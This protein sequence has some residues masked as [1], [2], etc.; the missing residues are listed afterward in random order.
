MSAST[1]A[2]HS[3][4]TVAEI[5][6][7]MTTYAL[8]GAA[9]FVA[10]RHLH[11]IRDTGGKLVAAVDPHDSVGVLD[12]YFPE[13]RYFS[14]VERFDRH[15]EKLRRIGNGVDYVSICTPNYLHD[16]HVRLALRLRAHAIC[17]KPLAISPWNLDQLA[18]LETEYDRRVY[19]VFQLRTVP[20]LQKLRAELKASAGRHDVMLDYVT[21]RGPWYLY[22]WKGDPRK[23]GGLLFN[24]GVHLFDVLLWL[25]GPII[26]PAPQL[27]V[28]EPTR[29][30][31]DLA[32][33]RANV[34]FRLSIRPCDL[35][36]G[37]SGPYRAITIDGER[38]PLT[39]GTV[40]RHVDVYQDIL[41]GNGLGIADARPVIDLAH[42]LI[43]SA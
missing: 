40:D 30:A 42:T 15:L 21:P 34:R 17:E 8:M 37:H 39:D 28:S 32:L 35:P 6:S 41:D 13:A 38:I 43:Q 5:E 36:P 10:P 9:G 18:E 31:G 3:S 12:S 33:E 24:I 19:T 11:A 16:A 4:S 25:F 27:F 7:D 20:R 29:V 2:L 22:S 26:A 23:S 1:A 14:E